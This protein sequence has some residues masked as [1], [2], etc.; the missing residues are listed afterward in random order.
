MTHISQLLKTIKSKLSSQS[1][2]P[3]LDAQVLVAHAMGK[4]RSWVLAHPEAY[5]GDAAQARLAEALK[6]LE[7]G[8]PLPYVLGEWEFFGLNFM[9]TEDVLIPRPET[10]IL[11]ERAIDWLKVHPNHRKAIDIGT[12]SGCIAVSLGVHISDVTIC[13][14]DI[15]STA[16]HTAC[17]NVLR[18]DL[19]G[20][21]YPLQSD[22][23]VPLP[24]AVGSIDVICANLPY[25]PNETLVHLE[26]Y[27]R[28]PSLA[29]E[30]GQSGLDLIGSLLAE[31]PRILAPEG[32]ILLEIDARQGKTV[33]ALARSTFPQATITLLQ[34]LAGL[35]R[36]VMV[37][38]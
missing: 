30:G 16:L 24:L 8:D 19:G 12:G 31:A 14:Q 33:Q 22:V 18:Y 5:P 11:V 35:D 1:S 13:A 2:T 23:R 15:S 20:R 4:S 38:T 17:Q 7:S 9:L 6:R 3:S 36:V 27:G 34:D 32:M 37:D 10:E 28:E 21:V 25:I 26:V 29:L